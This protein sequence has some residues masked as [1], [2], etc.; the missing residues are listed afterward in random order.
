MAMIRHIGKFY[1]NGSEIEPAGSPTPVDNS[2]FSMNLQN[3]S[4][5]Y[6][7]PGFS[8]SKVSDWSIRIGTLSTLINQSDW[9]GHDETWGGQSTFITISQATSGLS[10]SVRVIKIDDYDPRH[11][12]AYF[13][14]VQPDQPVFGTAGDPWTPLNDATYNDLYQ[15]FVESTPENPMMF[16]KAEG[17]T[18]D[19]YL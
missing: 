3:H 4:G 6:G 8:I 2:A 9:V 5:G 15:M 13:E 14:I 7:M 17:Y 16:S 11:G 12:Q 18:S 1:Q 10:R 19:L